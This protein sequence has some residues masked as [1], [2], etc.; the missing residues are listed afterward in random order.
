MMCDKVTIILLNDA[1]EMRARQIDELKRYTARKEELE[2]KLKILRAEIR[3]TED[4]IRLIERE[5]V[6]NPIPP[7]LK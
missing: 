3:L 6:T 1:R 2:V 5:T 7:V 4:I